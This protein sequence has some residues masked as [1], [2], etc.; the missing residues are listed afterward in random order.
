MRIMHAV[1]GLN[2]V[3]GGPSRTV[4]ALCNAQVG[5]HRTV[6]LVS[7]KFIG[8]SSPAIAPESAEVQI[9]LLPALYSE[10]LRMALPLCSS[11]VLYEEIKEFKPDLVHGHGLWHWFNHSVSVAAQRS[12]VIEVVSPR[13]MLM[14]WSM[15]KSFRRKKLIWSTYQDRDLRRARA[16]IATSHEEA[17]DI[18]ELGFDQPIAVIPNGVVLP[19][20]ETPRRSRADASRAVFLS[21]IHPKKGLLNLVQAW[22]KV[23]PKDWKLVIAGPDELGHVREVLRLID[24]LGVNSQIELVGPIPEQEKLAFLASCDLAILP[25]VSENFGMMVAEAL[26][27]GLPVIASTGTPWSSLVEFG[28]GWWVP[29]DVLSLGEAIILAT[30]KTANELEMMGQRGRDLVETRYSWRAVGVE[31]LAF[32]HW[33]LYGGREPRSMY[34]GVGETPLTTL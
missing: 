33:L 21:R 27:V 19:A 8:L 5:P 16:F 30:G 34:R 29:N 2:E 12:N 1:A 28:C 24:R 32:Y 11:R 31:T 20:Y 7:Q 15:S 4:P 9:S 25:S 23:N 26:A 6:R 3:F 22:A 13:G 10:F 14:K 18:R 17:A